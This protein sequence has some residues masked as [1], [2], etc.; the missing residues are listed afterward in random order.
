[1]NNGIVGRKG[2]RVPS[3][4]FAWRSAIGKT[5]TIFARAYSIHIVRGMVRYYSYWLARTTS[6]L[7]WKSRKYVWY[8]M[9]RYGVWTLNSS[10]Q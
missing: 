6:P 3:T 10:T 2:L 9:V 5:D 8:C 4:T 7:A 1:M